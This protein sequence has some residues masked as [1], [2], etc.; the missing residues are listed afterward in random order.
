MVK[1]MKQMTQDQWRD[2]TYGKIKQSILD[3]L[4]LSVPSEMWK[5]PTEYSFPPT[6]GSKLLEKI[7][8]VI[9]EEFVEKNER[10]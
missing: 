2:E 5:P 8:D 6:R 4:L 3:L 1:Q 10:Y 7:M 9:E